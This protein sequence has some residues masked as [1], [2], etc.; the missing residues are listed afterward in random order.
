MRPVL[1]HRLADIDPQ[2]GL[3]VSWVGRLNNLHTF[4]WPKLFA[5]NNF[6]LGIRP[7]ARVATTKYASA[8][9]WIESG[10]TWL[11]WGGGIPLLAGLLDVVFGAWL[12]NGPRARGRADAGGAAAVGVVSAIAVITVCMMLDPH[13]TYRGSA[14]LLFALLALVAVRAIDV[15]PPRDD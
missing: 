7:A 6:I 4:F 3:P 15:P 2:R 13:L 11:L 9:V 1:T 10:Y 14:D 5:G 8:W 12:E